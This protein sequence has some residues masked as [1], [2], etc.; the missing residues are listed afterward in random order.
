MSGESPATSRRPASRIRSTRRAASPSRSRRERQRLPVVTLVEEPDQ[1]VAADLVEHVAEPGDVADR[2]GH[3]LLA[4]LEHPVV[5]P[6]LRERLPARG[7]RLRRLVLV[8][9][10]D[11]VVAAAVD[12]E[13]H[14]ERLLRHRRALDVPTGPAPAPGRVPGGVLDSLWAF[15]SAKSSGSRLSAAPSMPSPWSI[16]LEVAVGERAVLRERADG[17]VHVA[18]ASYACSRAT[19]SSI[20]ATISPTISVARGSWS[21]RPRPSRSVSPM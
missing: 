10:E 7:Q 5:H 16:C 19:R 2:L 11:Q 21:G 18:A 13:A 20:S 3:L 1:R 8:V 14:A 4:H 15:Q 9:R 12:L 17:E 6:D